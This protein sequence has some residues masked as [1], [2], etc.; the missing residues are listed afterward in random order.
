MNRIIILSFLL[1]SNLIGHAQ[2]EP[3]TSFFW[4]TQFLGNPAFTGIDSRHEA[5][6]LYRNQWDKVNGAPNTVL[7]NYTARVQKLHGGA[8]VSYIH[9]AIGFNREHQVLTHYAFHQKLKE[10]YVLSAGISLGWMRMYINPNWI[11]PTTLNDPLLPGKSHEDIFQ[12]NAGLAFIAEN[13]RIGLGATQLNSGNRTSNGAYNPTIHSRLFGEYRFNLKENLKL[14]PR[15]QFIT[16]F[17][18]SSDSW[19]LGL[20]S[21]KLWGGISYSGLFGSNYIGAMLGYDFYGKYRLG[22]TFEYST[23]KFSS[24]SKGTHEIVLSFSLDGF[25]RKPMALQPDSIYK[26][27]LKQ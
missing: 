12:L 15:V 2:Q 16:D 27:V 24:I 7:V 13:W 19:S 26:M 6:A 14:I 4:H 10:K 3:A 20:Y 11:A 21:N 18:K 9:D 22:Y 25:Q 5:N 23:N 8:G 17:V 1:I